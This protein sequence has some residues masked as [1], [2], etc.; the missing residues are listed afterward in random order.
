MWAAATGSLVGAQLLL[1]LFAPLR[2]TFTSP[3]MLFW[4]VV[5]AASGC[6]IAAML[7]LRIAIRD[8]L[9]E[10]GLMSSFAVAVSA[11]CRSGET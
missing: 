3:V 8:D 11:W 10:L 7:S 5:I 1:A 4:V 9:P 6:V 2:W